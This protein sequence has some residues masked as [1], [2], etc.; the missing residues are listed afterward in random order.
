MKIYRDKYA[1]VIQTDC[2]SSTQRRR[3]S[4]IADADEA[5]EAI[6]G[7]CSLQARENR[8]LVEELDEEVR[9]QEATKDVCNLMHEAS[10]RLTTKPQ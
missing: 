7:F 1:V 4:T 9:L 2:Q 10:M 6:R 5:L 3:F 8:K